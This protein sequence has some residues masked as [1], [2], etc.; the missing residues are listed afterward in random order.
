VLVEGQLGMSVNFP[1]DRHKVFEETV[2]KL[3]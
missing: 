1:T 3:G 2:G